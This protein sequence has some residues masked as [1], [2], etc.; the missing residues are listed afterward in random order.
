MRDTQKLRAVVLVPGEAAAAAG[1]GLMYPELL[2]KSVLRSITGQFHSLQLVL[3]GEE[4][5][6]ACLAQLFKQQD[7]V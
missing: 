6:G 4:L 3:K 2:G 5:T 7:D 1:L